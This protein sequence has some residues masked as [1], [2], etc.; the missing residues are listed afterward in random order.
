VAQFEAHL[1]LTGYGKIAFT[2]AYLTYGFRAAI[3]TPGNSEPMEI[4]EF[5][6]LARIG[7]VAVYE[8]D[9]D[10][11][12]AEIP[13]SGPYIRDPIWIPFASYT[14]FTLTHAPI[15]QTGLDGFIYFLYPGITLDSMW[16]Y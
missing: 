16:G 13:E 4:S 11:H 7:Y 8:Y 9:V 1:G 14:Y 6:R 5:P 2:D 3:S 15:E 10:S 12:P